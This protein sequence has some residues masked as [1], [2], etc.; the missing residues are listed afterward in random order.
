GRSPSP[1]TTVCWRW[2]RRG[3]PRPPGWRSWRDRWGSP[4]PM[5]WRSG[6]CLTTSRCCGGPG[7]VWRWAMRTRRR[8]RR[9]TRSPRRTPMTG[10]PGCWSGGGCSTGSRAV[11]SQGRYL[12]GID[13]RGEAFQLHRIGVR[14]RQRDLQ[15]HPVDHPDDPAVLPV[16]VQ[17]AVLEVLHDPL[18]L[19]DLRA[20]RQAE[21]AAFEAERTPDGVDGAG[22]RLRT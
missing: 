16:E 5:W 8:S 14:F 11:E 12:S 9:P 7:W 21:Q 17:R 20:G 10:W 3:S 18:R 15:L 1:P 6:T 4:P 19:V 13:R 22:Q 2:C